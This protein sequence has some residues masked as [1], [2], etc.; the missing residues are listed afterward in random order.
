MQDIKDTNPFIHAGFSWYLV[1]QKMFKVTNLFPTFVAAIMKLQHQNYFF[2]YL[3]LD[4]QNNPSQQNNVAF[5]ED[6]QKMNI[7]YVF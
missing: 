2:V 3:K 6:N 7:F 4:L 5:I 1:N